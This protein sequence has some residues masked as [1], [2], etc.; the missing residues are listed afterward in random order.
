[1]ATRLLADSV[2]KRTKL[3]LLV[4]ALLGVC[5][6]VFVV[7]PAARAE[8]KLIKTSPE[9]N[10][11]L[12]YNNSPVRVTLTFNEKLRAD[13]STFSIKREDGVDKDVI[14]NPKVNPDNPTEMF[15][16]LP[17]R[18]ELGSDRYTV[19]YTVVSEADSSVGAGSSQFFILPQGKSVFDLGY[20]FTTPS[21][22]FTSDW[23]G[24]N[25]PPLG[26]IYFFIALLGTI[27]ANFFYFYGRYQFFSKNRLVFTIVSQASKNLAIITS[28]AFVFFLC[29][30]AVLQPFNARVFLYAI[31]IYFLFLIVRGAIYMSRKFPKAR[32]EWEALQ[33]KNKPKKVATPVVA[34]SSASADAGSSNSPEGE[35]KAAD[36]SEKP[37]GL[38]KRGEKRRAKKK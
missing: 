3:I 6:F 13:T 35:D 15:A 37:R 26:T 27:V 4:A 14:I 16:D 21:S 9:A 23:K 25:Y 5:F 31:A 1:M 2:K 18:Q 34:T 36:G 28:L 10:T 29:R 11:Y 32:A 7:M 20:L 12:E 8:P 19:T 38:S 17:T 33:L 24:Y 22:A 30:I